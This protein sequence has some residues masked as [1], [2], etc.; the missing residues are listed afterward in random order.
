[1]FL[2]EKLCDRRF[3]IGADELKLVPGRLGTSV[4]VSAIASVLTGHSDRGPVNVRA[5]PDI[6]GKPGVI[7]V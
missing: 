2:T 7:V 6:P 5:N 3:G 1:V 4:T